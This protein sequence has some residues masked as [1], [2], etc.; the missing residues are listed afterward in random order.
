MAIDNNSYESSYSEADFW[1][2]MK[3]NAAKIPGLKRVFVLYYVM[4]DETT[5]VWAKTIIVAALGY[6]VCPVDFIPD[7]IPVAGWS[8]DAG[9][10]GSALAAVRVCIDE[11]H[12]ELAE[13]AV[14]RLLT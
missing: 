11:M 7:L 10:I 4:K 8:D 12:E 5:P 3:R 1:R 13:Q 2:I 14:Q 6:A 9:V